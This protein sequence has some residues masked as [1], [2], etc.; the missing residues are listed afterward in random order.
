MYGIVDDIN[1]TGSPTSARLN[2]R[3]RI[4]AE[5]GLQVQDIVEWEVSSEK[6]KKVARIRKLE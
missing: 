6:D 2:I 5:L 3:R 4:V 1:E